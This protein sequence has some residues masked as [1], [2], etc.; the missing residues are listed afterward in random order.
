MRLIARI[1]LHI[2]ANALAILIAEWILPGFTFW[3][4]WTELL[5]AAIILG[6]A[7]SLIKPVLKL[8]ALPIIILTL[9]LFSV[10]INIFLLYA[11]AG[12]IPS[13]QIAGFWTAL[14]ATFIISIVNN[15]ILSI[16]KR[17]SE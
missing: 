2:I 11:V 7:N 17:E 9:G 8:L 10:I 5:L 14:G 1:I 4:D 13:L 15:V 6:I 16:G 12:I 3:G